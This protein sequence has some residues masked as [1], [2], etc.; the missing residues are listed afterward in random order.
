MALLVLIAICAF[1]AFIIL[2]QAKKQKY[3]KAIVKRTNL[4]ASNTEQNRSKPNQTNPGQGV[5]TPPIHGSE[6][7]QSKERLVT[8]WEDEKDAWEESDLE[9][10]Q[11]GEHVVFERSGSGSAE[12]NIILEIEYVDR[13]GVK[14]ERQIRVRRVSFNSDVSNAGIYAYCYARQAG[15]TFIASRISRCVDVRTGE[16]IADIPAFLLTEYKNSTYGRLEALHES[17][18]DEIAALVYVSKIDGR[19]TKAEKRAIALYLRNSLDCSDLSQADIIEDL[20]NETVM[21]RTQFQR[22]IGRLSRQSNFNRDAFMDA[23]NSIIGSSK[24]PPPPST[25][26]V[27][28]YITKKL[29]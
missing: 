21:S 5:H 16:V 9:Y 26:E 11:Y 12:S 4:S 29:S 13:N 25:V 22:C 7:D 15:R 17:H 23:V 27:L 8:S 18:S 19:S 28:E 10:G 20:R 1:M 3:T 24:S 14:S 6:R 2:S